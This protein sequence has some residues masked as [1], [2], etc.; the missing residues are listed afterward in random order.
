M[1]AEAAAQ[2]FNTDNYLTMPHGTATIVL[3]AGQRNAGVVT[4]FALL[5]RWEFFA[6]AFLFWENEKELAPQHFNTLLYTK[7]M[8]W[9]S[10]L[11]TN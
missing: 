1:A 3:K 9:V 5:P 7:Y 10:E 2:Q 6:Q 4:S 8:F 11:P